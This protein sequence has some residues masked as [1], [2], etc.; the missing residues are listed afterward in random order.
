[1]KAAVIQFP[2]SNGD[3]DLVKAVEHVGGAPELIWHRDTRSLGGYDAVLLPG[4]FS[5]GDYLR[6]GAIA[7]LSPIMEEVKAFAD[8]GGPV[9]GICNG[10]QTLCEAHLLPG[11]LVRNESLRFVGTDVRVRVERTDTVFTNEYTKGQILRIPIAH[12]EGSYEADE[13]TLDRLEG[14]GRIVF[15]YVDAAGEPTEGCNPNGSCNNIA[16]IVSAAG[17]VLGMMP[18]PERAVE[19]LL[20]SSDG[21]ALFTSLVSTLV[22]SS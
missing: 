10:F 12:G 5:Y 2:G 7:S 19:D 8:A 17:N 18:H 1:M 21:E 20:G 13:Q 22:R 3:Y 4:G 9:L 14:E 6:A 11:A 16:G 15:R